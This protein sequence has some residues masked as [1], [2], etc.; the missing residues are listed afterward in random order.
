MTTIRDLAALAGVGLGTASR[1][2]SGHG[3]VAPETRRRVERAAQALNFEPLR[4]PRVA[5][6]S[7]IGLYVAG[8]NGN[9]HAP[10]L[11]TVDAELRA[12]GHRM[13]VANGRN[14]GD[15]RRRALDGIGLLLA[16]RCTGVI[17]STNALG[18]SDLLE[19]HRRSPRVAFINRRAAGIERHCFDV[20][21]ELGG[22]LAARALLERGHREIACI[23]GPDDAPD[24]RL[25]MA[26]FHAELA[27]HGVE[28]APAHRAEGDFSFAA[29]FAATRRLLEQAPRRWTALFCAN[30]VMA[31]AAISRLARD[32]VAVPRDV[33]VLGFDDADIATYTTPQ[34]TTV[35]IPVEHMAANACRFLLNECFGLAQPVARE[36]RPALVWRDSVAMRAG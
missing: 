29:G 21:H 18:E 23:G 16:R 27:R 7:S 34:L 32:G 2:L 30:D 20:D 22:R 11:Q 14:E 31:M 24:N 12:A 25:R 8:F 36:F 33:S 15:E 26:G 6:G 28:V 35:R 4:R 13:L 1:A 10:L 9:F 19:L 3:S 17:V 5:P